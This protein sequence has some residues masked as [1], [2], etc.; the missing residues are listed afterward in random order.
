MS[1]KPFS[2]K[3]FEDYVNTKFKKAFLDIL[4]S[5]KCGIPLPKGHGR[6]IDIDKFI[7]EFESAGYIDIDL[8]DINTEITYGN[9][10]PVILERDNT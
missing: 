7:D 4:D 9:K 2:S 3:L 6:L 5:I 1:R 10:I 8:Y